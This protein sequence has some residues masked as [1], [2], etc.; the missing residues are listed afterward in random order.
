MSEETIEPRRR[1]DLMFWLVSLLVGAPLLYFALAGPANWAM[2]RLYVGGVSWADEFSSVV[3]TLYFPLELAAEQWPP[4]QSFL[5][6]YVALFEPSDIYS[7]PAPP[8][9]TR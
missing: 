4:L 6:W 1:K 9:S 2:T 8:V 5:N 3:L 7:F